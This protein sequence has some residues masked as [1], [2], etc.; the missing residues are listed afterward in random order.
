[1]EHDHGKP[2]DGEKISPGQWASVVFAYLLVPFILFGISRDLTW[3]QGWLFSALVMAAGVGGRLLAERRHP[4]LMAERLRMGRGQ[5]VKSWDRGWAPL[6][7]FSLLYPHVIVSGLDRYYGWTTPFS[8]WVQVVA[9]AVIMLGYL[10]GVWA[11]VV[12]RF[13][14]FMVRIQNDRGHEVCD[15]GPYRYI[16][17]PGYSGNV[18]SSFGIG[19]L[20]DSWWVMI[21]AAIAMVIAVIRT[22]LEDK[23]LINELPGYQAYAARVRFRFVPGIW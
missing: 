12:N 5:D 6:L 3:V 7:G 19:F 13:F 14:S 4:G 2:T 11:L 17:H 16:R 8:I 10:V 22:I 1:M 15:S 20:L 18:I 9:F 21:P 23:T